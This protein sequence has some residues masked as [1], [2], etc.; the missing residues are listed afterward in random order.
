MK[1]YPINKSR[2][3]HRCEGCKK[4]IKKKSSYLKGLIYRARINYW[5]Y[6]HNKECMEK[7]DEDKKR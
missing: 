7:Y 1:A 6:F 5:L 4:D 3:V 2:V